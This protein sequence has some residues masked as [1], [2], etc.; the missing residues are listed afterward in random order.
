MVLPIRWRSAG[1]PWV[2]SLEAD[3]EVVGFG[4]DRTH[5]HVLGLSEL[6]PGSEPCTDRSSLDHRL[7]VAVVRQVLTTLAEV[8]VDAKDRTTA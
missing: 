1:G 6:P 3:L 2:P 4:A 5:L 8:L 7:A